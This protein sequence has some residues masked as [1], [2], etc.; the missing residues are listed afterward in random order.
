MK[1]TGKPQRSRAGFADLYLER[2]GSGSGAGLPDPN[3]D[4]SFIVTIPAFKEP[5]LGGSLLSLLACD[6]PGVH[7][8]I[9]VNINYPEGSGPDVIETSRRSRLVAEEISRGLTRS[10]VR[11]LCLW[12]PDVPVR[13]AGVGLAR[14]IVMDQAV[15][16]FNHI[17]RP[18]GVIISFDADSSCE[19]SYLKTIVDFYRR[20]PG[21]RTAN[22]Y[23][24]HPL[25]GNYESRIYRS[26]TQYE[27]YLRYM[28]LA[29]E[30]SGHPHGIHTVGSSFSLRARTYVRVN[31]MGRDKA[32]EDF[33]FLHKCI[34]QK[35]FWEIN[36][37]TVCPS[38]RESDR[39]SFGTGATI[40]Q[41]LQSDS[42]L[43]VYNFDSF[44]PLRE[45][46]AGAGLIWRQVSERTGSLTEL[47]TGHAGLDE[48]LFKRNA[49]ER[50]LAMHRNSA[51]EQTFTEK[52]FAW[53][54]GFMILRY[55][56]EVHKDYYKKEPVLDEARKLAG[57]LGIGAAASE[58]E[59]LIR[60]RNFEKARG[61]RKV[62]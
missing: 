34:L 59:M 10:D 21:A 27:L 37:T 25:S 54:N 43:E 40:H 7:W 20:H 60:Y 18:D 49:V 57:I 36:E 9:L 48:F 17:G 32:G 24:E 45:F 2:Y 15:R 38:V 28:R 41:Q 55:L 6:P 35:N 51:S 3:P 33:Y 16:R 46:F 26:I 23:Y 5:D 50:I 19:A 30:Y 62:I 31:G 13:H 14:K 29:V 53:F 47:R 56:N 1:P 42:V 44:E 58:T 61:N 12:N 4:L 39:V 11:I 52:F 8:E 22:I